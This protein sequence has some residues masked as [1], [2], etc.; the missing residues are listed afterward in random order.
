M[1]LNETDE[2]FGLNSVGFP[3][4]DLH[5]SD[6]RNEIGYDD[7]INP[8]CR[9]YVAP[10]IS[11]V[12]EVRKVDYRN[13]TIGKSE[14]T[15]YCDEGEVPF[16]YDYDVIFPPRASKLR[17]MKEF[18]FGCERKNP[19]DKLVDTTSSGRVPAAGNWSLISGRK[20]KVGPMSCHH[21]ANNDESKD[22]DEVIPYDHDYDVS[23]PKRQS[24][25]FVKLMFCM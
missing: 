25:W 17:R 18:F 8:F 9:N 10:D 14:V 7:S 5:L 4:R 3:S 21:I 13:E 20:H 19:K 15:D 22:D 2:I 6:L 23:F 24:S 16:D 12:T 11:V 1:R